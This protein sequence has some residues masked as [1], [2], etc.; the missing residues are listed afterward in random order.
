[1]ATGQAAEALR[2]IDSDS[3]ERTH[4][5]DTFFQQNVW[6]TIKSAQ[7]FRQL[8]TAYRTSSV[9]QGRIGVNVST[10]VSEM[11][12]RVMSPVLDR[13]VCTLMWKNYRNASAYEVWTAPGLCDSKE[14][15]TSIAT[16]LPGCSCYLKCSPSTTRTSVSVQC[17]L[18]V[19]CINP[20]L[21]I[22]CRLSAPTLTTPGGAKMGFSFNYFTSVLAKF[23]LA[24]SVLHAVKC[25]GVV[26]PE[27]GGTALR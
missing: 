22:I 20:G 21:P 23:T 16:A 15:A 5:I 11:T 8:Q 18:L 13:A 9:E 14:T 3:T 7:L 24:P 4:G 27:R 10:A 25:R 6:E 1:V 26:V 17:V 12:D 19:K 2:C